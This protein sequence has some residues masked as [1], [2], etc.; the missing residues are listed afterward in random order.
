[1]FERIV[2]KAKTI[3]IFCIL[4]GIFSETNNIVHV[5]MVLLLQ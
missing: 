5:G 3:Q 4:I 1:M 2:Y